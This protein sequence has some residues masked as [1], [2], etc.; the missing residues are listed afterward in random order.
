MEGN[1]DFHL[2]RLFE[3]YL[4]EGSFTHH[5]KPFVEEHEGQKFLVCHGDEIELEN[6]SYERYRKI[7]KSNI[8]KSLANGIVPHSFIKSV[9]ERASHTSRKYSAN[10]ENQVVRDKFVRSARQACEDYG[11]QKT[12][13][14][15]SHLTEHIKE[16]NFEYINNGFFPNSKCFSVFENGEFKKIDL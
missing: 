5:T 4:K 9:G 12:I 3:D 2:R 1:H 13:F 15:H 8:I 14:G 7:I 10:Y 6:P 16:D 11:V